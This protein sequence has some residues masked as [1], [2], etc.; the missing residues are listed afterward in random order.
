VAQSLAHIIYIVNPSLLRGCAEVERT[1][2]GWLP[3]RLPRSARA[4]CS[5]ARLR[6]A[7][8]QTPVS[9]PA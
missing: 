5:D 9:P 6:A 2:R 4:Q 8:S 7:E 3:H 1:E